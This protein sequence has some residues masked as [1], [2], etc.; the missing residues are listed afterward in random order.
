MSVI[1][2]LARCIGE[3]GKRIARSM[4]EALQSLTGVPEGRV[5]KDE[6]RGGRGM[7]FQREGT[8]Q[9]KHGRVECGCD[10]GMWSSQQWLKHGTLEAR[11][12]SGG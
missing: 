7:E 5:L 2:D 8:A 1:E 4:R 10:C 6:C 12:K 11:N 9:A 3:L